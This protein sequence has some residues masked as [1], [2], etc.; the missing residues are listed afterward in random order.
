MGTAATAGAA[1][2]FRDYGPDG[3]AGGLS[4]STP[5]QADDTTTRPSGSGPTRQTYARDSE[6]DYFL[7]PTRHGPGIYYLIIA[8]VFFM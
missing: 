4:R 2:P 3:A 1:G 8:A 7:W 5:L 6:P